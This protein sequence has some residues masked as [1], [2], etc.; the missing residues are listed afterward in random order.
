MRFQYIKVYQLSYRRRIAEISGSVLFALLI[1]TASGVK[2]F[3][4]GLVAMLACF[5]IASVVYGVLFWAYV[6]NFHHV[7]SR[8]SPSLSVS[9]TEGVQYQ[10]RMHDHSYQVH[11]MLVS[12]KPQGL[13]IRYPFSLFYPCSVFPFQFLVNEE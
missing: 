3:H 6:M 8:V 7:E 4:D 13:R 9:V 1:Y 2:T 11:F 12:S 5:L 10:F